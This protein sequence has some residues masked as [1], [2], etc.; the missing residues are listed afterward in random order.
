MMIHKK[1][2]VLV[3]GGMDS[4]ILAA[5]AK[6]EVEEML[7]LHVSYGQRTAERELKAFHSIADYFEVRERFIADISYLSEIGGSSLT[8]LAIQVPTGSGESDSIPSSYVPFRN[9]HFLS[10]AVSWG[11][12]KGATAAYIGALEN[13][14]SGYPDCRQS[15]IESFNRAVEAGTKPGTAITVKAPFVRLLKKDLI[16][17]GS[18]SLD[19]PLHLTWSCYRDNELACGECDSC[20][21]RLRAFSDAGY[22]DPIPYRTQVRR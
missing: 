2:V 12:V 1:A 20:V 7:F 13:D 6:R 10:I 17:M 15:F 3:S 5:F 4:C 21:L 14:T 11:E 18:S 8:D 16:L 22:R 9:A 19:A